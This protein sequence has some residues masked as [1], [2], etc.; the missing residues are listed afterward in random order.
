MALQSTSGNPVSC[1]L[2]PCAVTGVSRRAYFLQ[3]LGSEM[4]FPSPVRFHH[5]DSL[6][7]GGYSP[8]SLPV[9]SYYETMNHKPVMSRPTSDAGLKGPAPYISDQSHSTSSNRVLVPVL[10]LPAKPFRSLSD[11]ALL[12]VKLVK[13]RRRDTQEQQAA[14]QTPFQFVQFLSNQSAHSF[15]SFL[16]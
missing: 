16:F 15:S 2:Y 6:F 11:M 9:N 1:F 13:R 10:Y 5:P 7:P 4:H 8:S 3:P 12:P 14:C